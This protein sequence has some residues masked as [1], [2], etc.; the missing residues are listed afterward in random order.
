MYLYDLIQIYI[1]VLLQI[2]TI[3]MDIP[4]KFFMKKLILTALSFVTLSCVQANASMVTI[5]YIGETLATSNNIERTLIVN[6]NDGKYYN[7]AV[8]PLEE[9]I[10]NSDGSVSIPLEYLFINNTREDVY[11]KYN[12]YSNIFWGTAMDGV[13]RNMTAKIKNYGIVPAGNYYITLEIQATD[14]ETGEIAC[15]SSFSLQFIVPVIH[16]LNLYSENPQITVSTSEAFNKAQK[17]ANDTS[18][19]IYIRSNTDWILSIDTSDFDDTIGN[20]Y[21]RTTAG[22]GMV[23]WRLQESALMVP[24]REIVIA[25]GKAPAVNEH[26]AVEFSIENP[27]GK[28]IP[29]GSYTNRIKYI[30]REGDK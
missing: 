8:R 9:T 18:P 29:A 15:T 3:R 21:V 12:E 22:S 19:M 11:L 20:Y 17:K 2:V 1:E 28:V 6:S 14:V 7:I 27:N 30:L 16:E 4:R 10:T 24:H 25:R 5:D 23:T 26:V 13:P